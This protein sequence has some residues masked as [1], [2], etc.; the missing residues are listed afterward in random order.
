MEKSSPPNSQPNRSYIAKPLS[1]LHN[2]HIP[3]SPHYPSPWQPPTA[4][5]TLVGPGGLNPGR[6]PCTQPNR[7]SVLPSNTGKRKRDTS[8]GE[9]SSVGG[10]GPP[11]SGENTTEAS[12]P[13]ELLPQPAQRGRRNAASNVWVFAQPLNSSKPLPDDQQ[14]TTLEPCSAKKPDTPWFG[15]RLCP[16]SPECIVS[17]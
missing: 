10:F 6:L 5:K 1:D 2:Y 13:S 16:D 11:P 9:A 17:C 14:P 8:S 15:C 7:Q 3:S 12:S 4:N